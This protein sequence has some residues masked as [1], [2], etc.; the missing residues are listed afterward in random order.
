MLLECARMDESVILKKE[1]P[2]EILYSC[3]MLLHKRL[4]VFCVC[5]KKT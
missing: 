1:K 4:L 5:N 3:Q 2:L